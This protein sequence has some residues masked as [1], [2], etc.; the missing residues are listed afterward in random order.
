[1]AKQLSLGSIPFDNGDNI[2]QTKE[3]ANI[4]LSFWVF[5]GMNET[6]PLCT[7]FYVACVVDYSLITLLLVS[8]LST[9]SFYSFQ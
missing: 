6:L 1:M 3:A 4:V 2:E 5:K 7:V 8:N 9:S